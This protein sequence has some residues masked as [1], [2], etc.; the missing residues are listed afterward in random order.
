M[1]KKLLE[2]FTLLR[3][4]GRIYTQKILDGNTE[5]KSHLRLSQIKALYA[6]RDKD[7]LSMKSLAENIGVKL[8]N[9]TMMIDNLS[10]DGIVE[11]G[12]D[13]R[14]RRKVIVRLTP[15]GIKIRENFL[16]HRSIIAKALFANL[17]AREKKELLKSLDSVC[18]ILEKAFVGAE[19]R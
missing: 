18:R 6:F 17:N 13:E 14:D 7:C 10:G 3:E 15:K 11:R 9:M 16:S 5:Y 19:R 12:R 2:H 1:D 8:P 4:L